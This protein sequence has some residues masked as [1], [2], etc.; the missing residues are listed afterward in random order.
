VGVT[1]WCFGFE[2]RALAGETVGLLLLPPAH[3]LV[4]HLEH[5]LARPWQRAALDQRLEHPLVRDLR[6]DALGE[7]PHRLE[8]PVDTRGDDRSSRAFA[9]ALHRVEAE[10]DL[11]ADD[12]EVDV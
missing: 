5:P 8:R 6:V 2:D 1:G 7:V 12:R 3:R 9:D 10:A 11:P 4:E